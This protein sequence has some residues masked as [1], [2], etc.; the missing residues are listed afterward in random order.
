MWLA[1]LLASELDVSDLSLKQYIP[2]QF[3]FARRLC[4]PFQ[5]ICW[6]FVSRLDVDWALEFSPST[7]QLSFI[8]LSRLCDTQTRME[9]IRQF[10]FLGSELS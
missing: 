1:R 6:V 4:P 8:H 7:T 3:L 10:N 2:M 9:R 5:A